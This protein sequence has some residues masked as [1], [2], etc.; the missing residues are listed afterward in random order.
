M[1]TA[2]GRDGDYWNYV[3]IIENP[4]AD[5]VFADSQITVEALAEDGTILDSSS[6]WTTVLSGEMAL[7][8][9]FLQVGQG[10]ITAL[11][12]RGPEPETAVYAAAEE[13]GAFEVSDIFAASDM[14]S[15]DVTGT[16]SS[17]FSEEQQGFI[18]T[19]IA[20]AADGVILNADRAY[21]ERLPVDGKTQ[22]QVTFVDPLPEDAT[23]EA[24]VTF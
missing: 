23:Y 4:N 15:T 7:S 2:F 20:R 22:F 18:V 14:Y 24:Y 8:G 11:E 1:E 19:V 5:Y 3:V 16:V 12:V 21:V 9:K 17:D 6:D 10:K 13:T